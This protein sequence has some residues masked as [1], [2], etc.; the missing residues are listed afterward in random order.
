MKT[1]HKN[2]VSMKQK[3]R[4]SSKFEHHSLCVSAAR[5]GRHQKENDVTPSRN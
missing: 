3:K 5:Y 4:D 1:V 2:I